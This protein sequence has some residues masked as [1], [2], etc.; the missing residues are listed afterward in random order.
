M[1]RKDFENK[2]IELIN[3]LIGIENLYLPYFQL[4]NGDIISI[5]IGPLNGTVK[6]H[7]GSLMIYRYLTNRKDDLHLKILAE[8]VYQHH[9]DEQLEKILDNL[10]LETVRHI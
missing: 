6:C 10:K 2:F 4:P 3:I 5:S 7:H 9:N 8:Y 1:D